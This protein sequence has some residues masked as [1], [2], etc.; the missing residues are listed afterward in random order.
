MPNLAGIYWLCWC[1][2]GEPERWG[3]V[4]GMRVIRNSMMLW[5]LDG[6]SSPLQEIRGDLENWSLHF[7]PGWLA[8]WEHWNQAVSHK[9]IIKNTITKASLQRRSEAFS[10]LWN[11]SNPN[12]CVSSYATAFTIIACSKVAFSPSV[13]MNSKINLPVSNSSCIYIVLPTYLRKTE[14]FLQGK[15]FMS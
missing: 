3:L 13:L 14:Y 4:P 12:C 8:F 9:K 2:A 5:S 11:A 10:T 15:V 6:S 1:S 7:P